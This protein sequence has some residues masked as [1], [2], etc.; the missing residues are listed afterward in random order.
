MNYNNNEG[1]QHLGE[2]EV[3]VDLKFLSEAVT[4]QA[5]LEGSIT[6]SQYVQVKNVEFLDEDEKLICNCNVFQELVN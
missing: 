6:I 1:A 2:F 3:G 4:Y 5:R